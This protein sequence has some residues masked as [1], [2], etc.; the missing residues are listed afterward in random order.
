MIGAAPGVASAGVGALAAVVASK[1]AGTAARGLLGRVSLL[2]NSESRARSEAMRYFI[3]DV[4]V[5][6]R[7]GVTALEVRQA[8]RAELVRERSFRQR[9]SARLRLNLARATREPDD[10]RRKVRVQK[11]IEAERRYSKQR[12][13]A[14]AARVA[15]AANARNVR[16]RSP[17]G[18]VWMLG[19][20]KEHCPGCAYLHG[21]AL[22]WTALVAAGYLPPVGPGCGCEL[23]GMRAAWLAGL[24]PTRLRKPTDADSLAAI[25]VAR[26]LG[27]PHKHDGGATMIGAL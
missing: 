5:K 7:P 15:G 19:H 4:M 14:I 2:L 10:D 8:A 6:F 12:D 3:S 21:R 16:D 1:Y 20:R 11:V 25:A 9:Q 22:T 24:T 13:R 18:A 26:E 27:H 23:H 17:E